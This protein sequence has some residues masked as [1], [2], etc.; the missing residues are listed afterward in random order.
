V[1]NV[2]IT[3]DASGMVTE[4]RPTWNRLNLPNPYSDELLAAVRAAAALWR[5]VPARNVYWRQDGSGNP[6]FDHADTVIC[7]TDLRFTF[8]PTVSTQ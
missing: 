4:V 6:V 7:Q 3:I 2:T 5:F 1:V 8:Q